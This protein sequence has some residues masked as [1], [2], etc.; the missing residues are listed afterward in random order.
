VQY[1]TSN[2]TAIAGTDYLATNNVLNF[3]T[4]ETFKTFNVQILRNTAITGD[5]IFNISL[6][7]PSGTGQLV[8][9]F[10]TAVTI[11]DTDS[12]L[13]F[14]AASNTVSEA[15]GFASV[16]VLRS[17]SALGAISVN[18]FTTDGTAT[19]G[20][21]YASTNGVLNFADGQVSN[22]FN[23][24][25][26]N[27]NVV[28]GDQTVN[29]TL[30]NPTGG[31]QLASPSNS[32]LL[33]T[34]DD[35]GFSFSSGSYSVSESGV[36]API[37]VQR[38]GFTNS[39]VSVNF[40][41]SDGTAHAGTKYQATNGTLIFGPTEVS[42]SFNVFVIDN[43]TIEGN[44]TINLA[45][46]S[47]SAGASLLN[48]NSA[49]LTV[50]DND[51]SLVL[52]AGA[53]II[54]ET[55]AG[56]ANGGI[57]P[58]ET[59]TMWFSLR[60]ALGQNTTNLVATLLATN[61]VTAPSGPQ[62]YGVLV[63]NGPSKARQFTFTAN[64][65]NGTQL[66]AVLQLQDGASNIGTATFAFTL[67][68]TTNSFTNNGVINILD[69]S[70]GSPY[71]ATI[72]VS[73][74]SGT[75]DKV[76]A[77]LSNLSHANLLD[78]SILLMGPTGTNTLL[79]AK[80]GGGNPVNNVTLT[81]DDAGPALTGS[82]PTS[83][84]YRP[85]QFATNIP[86]PASPGPGLLPKPFGT[87]LGAFTNTNPNGVWSLFVFDDTGLDAGAI[88]N[89]WSLNFSTLGVLPPVVDLVAGLASSAGVSVVGSN[90]TYTISVTNAGPST[91]TG[92]TIS[93]VIPAGVTVISNGTSQG[94]WTT[95]GGTLV[96]NLGTLVKDAT[97]TATLVFSPSLVGQLT[98][99]VTLTGLASEA[100]P[101]NNAAS[102]ITSVVVPTADLAIGVSDAPDPLL[103]GSNLTYTIVIT[104][105]GPATAANVL[106]TNTLPPGVAFVSINPG[107]G[108]NNS[109]TV[110]ANL[111]SIGS[112]LTSTFSIVVKPSAVG[113]YTNDASV[114]SSVTDPLKGNNKASTKTVVEQVQL[115]FSINA[116]S[117]TFTWPA[118]ATGYTLET[119]PSLAPGSWTP[120]SPPPTII[121][122]Q[123]TVV[124]SAT[125]A[126][127]FYRLRTQLP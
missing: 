26:I 73:A 16:F 78:V 102:V 122:G 103:L 34:D 47:P 37:T 19:A 97:A 70:P 85:T 29:L 23:V 20:V 12:S 113:T 38:T 86:F 8:D 2:V 88:N 22:S 17:G 14:A 32:V 96:C 117:L 40:A 68:R 58:G 106:V 123:Y 109:G 112:G 21:R 90:L 71:P 76:T 67:G 48:P 13:R 83:G 43:S 72:N 6:S 18:Y 92:V 120:V 119:S 91:A 60:N 30:V 74:L 9:P 81:F 82:T 54:A 53:A 33:I 95:N 31:A 66:N 104:N 42:K 108:T 115:N 45:L 27:D 41:T 7:N 62:N 65:T 125:G 36:F 61:G 57:D 114:G 87:Q 89:G 1:A 118:T 98:N 35:S 4:G 46:S 79:M 124:V 10:V 15:G 116:S 59:V 56:P 101:A 84:T 93:D 105:L 5:R 107:V 69:N 49:V 50:I 99:T 44:Q 25:L 100:N 64:G 94:T 28:Q 126:G 24:A 52:P 3:A 121:G 80:I 75:I 127:N 51:G 77:T 63:T 39:L 111:G 55:N 11:L 110:L